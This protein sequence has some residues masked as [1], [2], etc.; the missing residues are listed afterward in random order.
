[1]TTEHEDDWADRHVARWRDHWIDVHFDDQVEAIVT[2]IDRLVRHFQRTTKEALAEVGLQDF[3]YKT[4]HHLMIRETPGQ[5][6]PSALAQ[7]LE[8]SGAGMTGRLDLLEK[9]GWIQRRASPDDRRRVDIEITRAGADVWRRAM[10]LRGRS[11][12]Q[13]VTELTQEER[14]TLARLLKKLTLAAEAAESPPNS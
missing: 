9:A 10:D 13:V 1:M 8:I 6:S 2:R 3:E 14:D 5:A 7:D 4:L 11:E 12:E